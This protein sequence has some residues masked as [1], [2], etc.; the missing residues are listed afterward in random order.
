[1]VIGLIALTASVTIYTLS[2]PAF[3]SPTRPI[4]GGF[5]E[6]L[7]PCAL[8]AELPLDSEAKRI[9]LEGCQKATVLDYPT[10][11]DLFEKVILM[12]PNMSR[13]TSPWLMHGHGLGMMTAMMPSFV[14]AR[15]GLFEAERY[16]TGGDLGNLGV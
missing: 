14:S 8:P 5:A 6:P 16:D 12:E 2:S 10:A 15:I 7:N 9:Y 11:R 3:A 13:H 4:R 1:M